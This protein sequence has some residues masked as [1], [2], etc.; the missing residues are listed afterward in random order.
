MNRHCKYF[1]LTCIKVPFTFAIIANVSQKSIATPIF[2]PR[3]SLSHFTRY[4]RFSNLQSLLTFHILSCIVVC[5]TQGLLLSLRMY[6]QA[7]SQRKKRRMSSS[8]NT[9]PASNMP[10]SSDHPRPAKN[11]LHALPSTLWPAGASRPVITPTRLGTAQIRMNTMF[12]AQM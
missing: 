1:T 7:D 5:H 12:A 11:A 3:P 8:S 4:L 10:G 9:D 6:E 2:T